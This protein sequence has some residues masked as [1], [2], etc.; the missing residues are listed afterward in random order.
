[1]IIIDLAKCIFSSFY[2][3]L[4]I[5]KSSWFTHTLPVSL[6]SANLNQQ[7]SKTC[8]HFF[9]NFFWLL[10]F[11]VHSAAHCHL[12]WF[13]HKTESHP[14]VQKDYPCRS[15]LTICLCPSANCKS[16]YLH[17]LFYAIAISFYI[18]PSVVVLCYYIIFG[19]PELM[20]YLLLGQ[21]VAILLSATASDSTTFAT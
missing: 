6:H 14:R 8:T 5:F 21:H 11:H 3:L 1:M 2:N 4:Y 13:V 9:Y 10:I 16:L 7:M 17:F 18:I 15:V 19:Q 20:M 12:Y